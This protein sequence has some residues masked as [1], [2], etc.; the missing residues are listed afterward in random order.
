MHQKPFLYALIKP[1]K[2]NVVFVMC[3]RVFIPYLS[4]LFCLSF[5]HF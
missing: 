3:V 5:A 4:K 1:P 2:Y